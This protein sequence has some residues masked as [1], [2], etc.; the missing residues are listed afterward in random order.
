M[1]RLSDQELEFLGDTYQEIR[2]SPTMMRCYP[3][4]EK[5]IEEYVNARIK[6]I[7]NIYMTNL[8]RRNVR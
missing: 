3:T 1:I 8:R 5:F 7:K 2:R 4:F 6:N